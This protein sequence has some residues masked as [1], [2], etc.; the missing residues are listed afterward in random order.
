M[1]VL[2]VSQGV[3]KIYGRFIRPDPNATD[4]ATFT[5]VTNVQCPKGVS[6]YISSQLKL[7]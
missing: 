3:T 4:G 7:T 6:L 5:F 1:Y 2:Y